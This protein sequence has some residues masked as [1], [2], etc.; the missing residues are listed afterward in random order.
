MRRTKGQSLLQKLPNDP[1]ISSVGQSKVLIMP[2]S[3]SPW[4]PFTYN[5]PCG[6]ILTQ[7]IL[8]SKVVCLQHSAVPQSDC[9]A[10]T[11]LV[12]HSACTNSSIAQTKHHKGREP[13]PTSL[14]RGNPAIWLPSDCTGWMLCKRWSP[15]HIKSA[16]E[17]WAFPAWACA[18]HSSL[19]PTTVLR[20]TTPKK[21]NLLFT[22]YSKRAG[23]GNSLP[24]ALFG[25]HR[26]SNTRSS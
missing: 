25:V 6:S 22:F 12:H 13:A 16:K 5:D 17:I 4:G 1:G 24:G 9:Q 15:L 10:G 21:S 7:T 19:K 23:L 18:K 8:W 11:A 26:I 20:T 14:C 3:Q 2:G